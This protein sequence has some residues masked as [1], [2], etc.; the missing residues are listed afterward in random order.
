[1][2]EGSVSV[3]EHAGK[4]CP[5]SRSAC[6]GICIYSEIMKSINIGIVV[7][8]TESRTIV[9]KNDLFLKEFENALD[10]DGYEI[11]YDLLIPKTGMPLDASSP[12]AA[13]PIHHDGRVYGYTIYRIAEKFIWI[14]IRDITEKIKLEAIAEA[15]NVTNNIG[16]VFS[17]VRHEIGNPINSIKTALSVLKANIDNYSREKMLSYLDRTLDDIARV[18]YLLKSLK[19]FNMYENPKLEHFNLRLFMNRFISLVEKDF[20]SKGIDIQY[21][22]YEG[23]EYGYSDTRALQQVMLNMIT[24]ALDALKERS[25]PYVFISVF[26]DE[27]DIQIVI[28][29]NGCGIT[30]EFQK[31]LFKPFFTSKSKGT[32][33]GLIIT[34][35]LLVNMGGTIAV[36][37]YQ[38]LGT[39][40]HI[41]IP[42]GRRDGQ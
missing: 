6:P 4:E 13:E 24:N 40:V 31:E 26:D 42:K 33:L 30:E 18:E 28:E 11:L 34:K 21:L 36:E 29:D 12:F 22:V 3:C 35:K 10:K 19:N 37:S 8:D 25:A 27:S 15:V 32:G 23:A 1:M 5:I 39:I 7:F 20:E 9:F 41:S 2:H 16:Y 38:G 14:F 17:G